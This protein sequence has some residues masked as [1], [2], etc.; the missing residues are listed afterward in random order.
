MEITN[1]CSYIQEV[2]LLRDKYIG[3]SHLRPLELLFRGHSDVDYQLL[4]NIA[5]GRQTSAD[6]TIFNGERNLIELAKYKFPDTFREEMKPVELLALLQHYGIPT[7]LLDVTENALVAL[8]FAC[9]NK[10]GT[11]GE[12]FVFLNDNAHVDNAPVIN[13]IADTCK[14]T[15]GA[16]YSLEHFFNAACNQPYFDEHRHIFEIA[17]SIDH[18]EW[19]AG[20]C[21]KP[22]FVYAPV[23]TLR[24]Q[25]QQGRFL[26]FSNRIVDNYLGQG[27]KAFDNIIDPFPKNHS[28]IKQKF[29]IKSDAKKKILRDLELCGIYETTLF[30]DSIDKVCSGIVDRVK[31]ML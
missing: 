9:C 8:Y 4:P 6:T 20:C 3:S 29:V 11:N 14:L 5:R 15:R 31:K 2:C 25:L 19:I 13:A 1:L 17:D 18:A 30:C 22:L 28:C 24:Q 26:L 23:H 27:N 12:V 10:P 21:N 7:R 16:T